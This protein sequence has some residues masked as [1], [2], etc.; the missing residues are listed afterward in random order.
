MRDYLAELLLPMAKRVDGPR[1]VRREAPEKFVMGP[2]GQRPSDAGQK[3]CTKHAARQRAISKGQ[4][5]VHAAI[6]GGDLVQM[7]SARYMLLMRG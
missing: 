1:L 6:Y 5:P 4:S 2:S 7:C 3:P